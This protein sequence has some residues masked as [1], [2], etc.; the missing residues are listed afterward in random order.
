[1]HP[2]LH[3]Y[4][5]LTAPTPC[6]AP[7][8]YPTRTPTSQRPQQ[9]QEP[10]TLTIIIPAQWRT[11]KGQEALLTSLWPGVALHFIYLYFSAPLAHYRP[12]LNHALTMA[13]PSI[14]K[15]S[16][17]FQVQASFQTSFAGGFS[18]ATPVHIISKPSFPLDTP[19]M[20]MACV[21]AIAWTVFASCL[22]Q[23]SCSACAQLRADPSYHHNTVLQ[24]QNYRLA[25]RVDKF[26]QQ[27][28]L[29]IRTGTGSWH[30]LA[31]HAVPRASSI[32]RSREHS[33][34][35][36]CIRCCASPL[37]VL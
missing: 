4:T 20:E 33:R 1:M 12:P 30:R 5:S 6:K 34:L 22:C 25:Q 27:S 9:P 3:R 24:C 29:P 11:R 23:C 21:V 36:V 18:A 8:Q 35:A 28:E 37:F 32:G 15:T 7:H 31:M 10:Q 26:P 16:Y 2:S 14:D 17:A 19:P 13:P